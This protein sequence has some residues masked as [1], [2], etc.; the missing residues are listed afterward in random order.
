MPE[1]R[2]DTVTWSYDHADSPLHVAFT[3]GIRAVDVVGAV[4]ELLLTG[5]RQPA[6]P[7]GARSSW[8]RT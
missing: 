8:W 5:G 4:G 2:D 7:S 6:W 1:A 3:P